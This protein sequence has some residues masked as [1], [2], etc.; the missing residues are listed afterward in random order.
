MRPRLSEVKVALM[1]WLLMTSH[2][3]RLRKGSK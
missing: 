3:V 1:P 2:V